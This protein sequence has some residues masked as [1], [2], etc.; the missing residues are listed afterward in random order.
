MKKILVSLVTHSAYK[1][2]CDNFIALFDKNWHNCAYDFCISVI[3]E[4]IS[5]L[6]Q[7]TVFHGENC[8]LPEALYNVVNNSEYDYCISFLGD[9][10]INKSIDNKMVESLI[11]ELDENN[12][13]YCNL[14]P[15]IAY[16]FHKK[17]ATKNTR[18]I[19]TSD[20]YN[21]SFVAFIASREFILKEFAGKVTDLDFE[22]KYLNRTNS[23]CYTYK[24]RVILTK[25]LFG[26]VPGICAGKWDRHALRLLQY[27]NPEVCFTNRKKI[28]N[29][30]M[31]KNDLIMIFQV[32]ASQKQRVV[33]KKV[34]SK[35]TKIKF[36]TDF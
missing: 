13:A 24:N 9:A 14:I 17:M 23:K 29:L 10:F 35:I 8:T 15:R 19:S 11:K 36:A 12:I 4:K 6:G 28:S 2:V 27:S 34:L 18:Y 7:N 25:N 16:R 30:E 31:I 26:L 3:G 1:D 5:F 20:S 33:F 22:K 32:F 21:M